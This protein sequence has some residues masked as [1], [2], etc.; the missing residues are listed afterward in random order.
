MNGLMPAAEGPPPVYNGA[1]PDQQPFDLEGA[2]AMAESIIWRDGGMDK[3]EEAVL[4]G[5]IQRQII[6]MQAV[7]AQAA[8][9]MAG[10]QPGLGSSGAS[11][12]EHNPFSGR[13]SSPMPG[14][15]EPA[16]Y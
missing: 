14:Y 15:D 1:P 3:A 7:Q 12:G 4:M 6:R 2:L 9:G 10:Q 5:W 16:P 8:Q 13:N 11:V